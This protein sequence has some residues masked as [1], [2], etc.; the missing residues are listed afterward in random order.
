MREAKPSLPLSQSNGLFFLKVELN[1][2]GLCSSIGMATVILLIAGT[3]QL[4]SLLLWNSQWC[5]QLQRRTCPFYLRSTLYF[6]EEEHRGDLNFNADNEELY[7]KS[8]LKW[9]SRRRGVLWEGNPPLGPQG[10]NSLFP[11]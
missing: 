9:T 7:I 11:Y 2:S 4:Q 10:H 3:G 6:S 5:S 8:A 1:A